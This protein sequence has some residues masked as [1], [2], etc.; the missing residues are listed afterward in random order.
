[1][2]LLFGKTP[3][4]LEFAEFLEQL[5]MLVVDGGLFFRIQ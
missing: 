3:S 5:G 4:L 2:T 1:M